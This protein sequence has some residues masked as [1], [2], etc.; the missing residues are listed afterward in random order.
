VDR[1]DCGPPG[2]A[3]ASNRAVR[4]RRGPLV[5][6]VPMGPASEALQQRFGRTQESAALGLGI[7][8]NGTGGGARPFWLEREEGCLVI[9]LSRD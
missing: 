3:A 8:R 6:L 7:G 5:N 4:H 2:T 9:D 1:R